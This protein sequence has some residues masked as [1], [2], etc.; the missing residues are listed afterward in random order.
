MERVRTVKFTASI[1]TNKR[2]IEREGESLSDLIE[3]LEADEITEYLANGVQSAICDCG[4][5]LSRGYCHIC[6][7]DE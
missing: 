4:E 1:D 6:D 3:W 2:T 5:G 7:N